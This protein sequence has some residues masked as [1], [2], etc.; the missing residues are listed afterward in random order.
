MENVFALVKELLQSE[1]IEYCAAMKISD[2]K[3][4]SKRRLPENAQSAIVFLMPYYSGKYPE[5]NI[6]LYSVPC[7][8]HL[9]LSYLKDALSPKLVQL[10]PQYRFD[11]FADTSPIDEVHASIFSGLGVL[12]LNRL[13][14]NERYGSYV[15][16][17]SIITDAVFKD[18]DYVTSAQNKKCLSCGACQKVCSFLSGK[19]DV[20]M[21]ELNQRKIITH[22]Q[23]CLVRSK[24]IR[25]G[26]DDC[27]TVCPLNKNAKITPIEF[28]KTNLTPHITPDGINNMTND[29]FS[30]RA[31]SWRKKQT[32]LRNISDK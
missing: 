19:T 31:Y 1:N 18:S 10:F 13:L 8:Y 28:F 2:C 4:I 9:Y 15:F 12:G 16:I 22:D 20:C 30:K 32:I 11:F 3:I 6:S 24:K 23:L 21:S 14:I 17:G 27:Q 25:W 26:C 7:D 5:R 29:E